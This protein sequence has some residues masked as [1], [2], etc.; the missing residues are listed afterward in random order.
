MKQKNLIQGFTLIELLI[1]IAI[2][3]VI[4]AVLFPNFMGFRQRARD[5]QRKSDLEQMRK[6]VEL[7]KLDRNPPAYPAAL[8]T[9]ICGQCWS[10]LVGCGGNIY[11]RKFPCDPAS[12]APTP[13]IYNIG[14]SDNLIYTLSACLENAADPDRDPTPV[15]GCS[16]WTAVSYTVHEP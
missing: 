3:S 16:S 5:T 11:M 2:V 14:A 10:S 6:A 1:A 12:T 4:M 13:Y 8:P 9:G 7:Y 15:P